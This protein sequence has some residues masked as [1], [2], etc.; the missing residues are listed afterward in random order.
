M[1]ENFRRK[2]EPQEEILKEGR[3]VPE[4]MIYLWAPR[5]KPVVPPLHTRLRPWALKRFGASGRASAGYPSVAESAVALT[6]GHRNDSVT[7]SAFIHGQSP[8]SSA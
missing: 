2:M 4:I 8:R 6:Q 3:D 5:A 7:E 1:T